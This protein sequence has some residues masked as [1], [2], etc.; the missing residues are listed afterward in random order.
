MSAEIEIAGRKIGPGHPCFVVAE[1]GINANGYLPNAHALVDAAAGAGCD[2]VKGQKR[3]VEVVYT[4]AELDAP[5][6]GP[7]GSTNRDLKLL[8]EFG[9]DECE[10][11]AAR[12]ASHG[13]TWSASPWDMASVEALG[14]IG[15]PWVKVASASITNLEL[16]RACASLGV[17]VIMSTG[18]S[19]TAE[20]DAAVEAVKG[21][22]LALLHTCS[23]YPSA[24]ADLHLSRM[25]WLRTRYGCVVGYSGHETG[26]LPSVEAVRLGAS[27][28]ERHVT[29]DRTMWGSDQ[30]A[31]LEPSGLRILVRAIREL[32]AF[33][34][35][36]RAE[37][38]SAVDAVTIAELAEVV[39]K[40]ARNRGV[41][42]TSRGTPGER[43]VLAVEEA[44]R[45]KLRRAG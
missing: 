19:T 12:A 27:I 34:D 43:R 37:S 8:L 15:V 14:T 1:Y 9:V 28:I 41:A 21:A 3:T 36:T 31:S 25:E 30:A 42:E 29:L 23:A 40:G 32:E 26:V 18:M 38:W 33:D 39:R 4:K 24:I 5:R 11:I 44:V 35:E 20:I 6:P 17:P 13:M 10:E 7:W 22:P 16:V 2:A 45:K